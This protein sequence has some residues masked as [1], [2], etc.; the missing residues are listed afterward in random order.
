MKLGF[1]SR[2]TVEDVQFAA[3]NG[4]DCIELD[5]FPGADMS[6]YDDVSELVKAS[7]DEDIEI[8]AL[9]QFGHQFLGDDTEAIATSDDV[10]AKA[11][12]LAQRVGAPVLITS[13]GRLED[14]PMEEQYK[15]VID[16][17]APKC[18]EVTA[19]GL[20]FGFYNCTWSNVV[21][22]PESWARVLPFLEGAGIKFDP[23]HPLY[24]Q[25]PYEPELLAAGSRI[26]HTHAKDVLWINGVRIPDPN[27]GFGQINWGVFFALLHHVGYDE[28]VCIEPHSAIYSGDRR[29]DFLK[30]SGAILRQYIPQS[31]AP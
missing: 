4:F 5:I 8:S 30:L 11:F 18:A 19:A 10:F 29:D 3:A 28:A 16:K 7:G 14:V 21:C 9:L 25:R 13:A 17:M 12:D 26:Y 24:E 6:A 23:S 22:D 20:K 31:C 15:M 27:P 2:G 1:C